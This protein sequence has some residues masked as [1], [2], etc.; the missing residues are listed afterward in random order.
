MNLDT[1]QLRVGAREIEELED[2]ERAA[3]VLR[4]DLASLDALVDQHQLAGPDFALQLRAD[5]IE[6]ARLRGDDPVA[7]EPAETE[8]AHA[9]RI[10]EG[11][12]LALGE[13][14]H[15]ERA[16]EPAHRVRERFAER[17]RI[18]G[19]QRGDHLRV[20]R[21]GELVALLGELLTQL[22]GVREVA[23]VAERDRARAAVLDEGLCV[24]PLRRTRRRVARVADCEVTAQPAELLLV[25]DLGD[26]PHVAERRDAAL[27]GNGD[28]GRLLPSVLKR[29]QP[30]VGHARDVAVRR[31]HSEE[32]AH[33]RTVPMR[34]RPFV[35]R[36]STSSGAHASRICPPEPAAAGSSTSASSPLCS[37]ASRSACPTPP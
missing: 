12:Q 22:G 5:E 1:G 31:P 13:R 6:R 2:A 35:P 37:S 36:R 27:V 29:E 19:D 21:R 8:R 9:A 15:R 16:V 32:A 7:V 14:D 34:S 10:A 17:S 33:Q 25:E 28:A 20:R 30:E 11:D 26:E 3:V 4:H 23:V 18:V 24:P